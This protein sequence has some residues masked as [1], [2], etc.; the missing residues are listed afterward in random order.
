[1]DM[2]KK[3]SQRD[4]MMNRSLPS[5]TQPIAI[6]D[7]TAALRA[8]AHA[9]RVHQHAVRSGDEAEIKRTKTALTRAKNK[10]DACYEY[11]TIRALRPKAYEKLMAEHPPTP[12]QSAAAPA[13]HEAPQWDRETFRPALLAACVEGDM[14]AE[15]WAVWLEEHSARG[16]GDKL[17]VVTLALNEAERLPESVMLPKG[18]PLTPSSR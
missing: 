6:D 17:F 10:H 7:P 2:T 11:L 13:P 18:S 1:M 4:R 16:E 5:V 9:E 14:T 15:D 12:E 8:L 3:A